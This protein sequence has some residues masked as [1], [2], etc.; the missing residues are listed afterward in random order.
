MPRKA[1]AD[2]FEGTVGQQRLNPRGLDVFQRGSE[3]KVV[4]S[5]IISCGLA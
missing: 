3:K 5:R 1:L 4:G 2:A